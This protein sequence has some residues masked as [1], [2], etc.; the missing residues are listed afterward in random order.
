MLSL[1]IAQNYVNSALRLADENGWNVAVSVA[2]SHGEQLCF[3]RMDGAS[4]QAGVLAAN[5]AYTSARDRQ[6]TS[7]LGQWARDTGKDMGYWTDA[8]ITG[9]GGG[10]PIYSGE[11]VIGAIGVSGLSE[12]EDEALAQ[13]ALKE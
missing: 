1:S 13:R 7:S 12:A 2:D 10:V 3:A 6:A 9:L 4:L 5:K 11:A 8:R